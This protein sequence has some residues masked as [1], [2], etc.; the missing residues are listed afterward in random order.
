MCIKVSYFIFVIPE[1][2]KHQACPFHSGQ[3]RN[4]YLLVL[5][6]VK[7]NLQICISYL[8][9]IINSHCVENSVDPEQLASTLFC[10]FMSGFMLF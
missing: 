1:V 4:F 2:W 9:I 6:Q 8:I 7:I 3:V 5:V 10:S